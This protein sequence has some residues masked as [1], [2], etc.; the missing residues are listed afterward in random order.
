[1]ATGQALL[2]RHPDMTRE[3]FSQHWEKKHATLLVPWALKYGVTYYAQVSPL[4]CPL[5]RFCP[6]SKR[7]PTGP[8]SDTPVLSS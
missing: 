6:V 8:Q 4:H 2:K 1:M 5:I 7:D 3:E